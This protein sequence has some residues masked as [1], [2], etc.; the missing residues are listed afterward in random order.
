MARKS[1]LRLCSKAFLEDAVDD[2]S[3][4]VVQ[5]KRF[6]V[7]YQIIL[8]SQDWNVV[9]DFKGQ[10]ICLLIAVFSVEN[11]LNDNISLAVAKI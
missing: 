7:W 11:L 9:L 1:D 6:D 2:K 10:K 8:S 4:F 3:V 5:Y